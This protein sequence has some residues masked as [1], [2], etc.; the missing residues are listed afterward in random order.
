MHLH[1]DCRQKIAHLDIKPEIILLNE[2]FDAKISDFVLAKL[3]DRDQ[4]YIITRMRGTPG[5]L[6]PEWLT[7]LITEKADVYSFGVVVTEILCGR[8]N[9]DYTQPEENINL[10]SVI[11]DKMKSEQLMDILDSK[12]FSVESATSDIEDAIRMAKLA[13]WCLESDS[14]RRPAMSVVVKIIEGAMD[15]E[16]DMQNHI[17]NATRA[18]QANIEILTNLSLP[19]SASLLSGPR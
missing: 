5:Y 7:H 14:N 19:H 4:S 10:T 15:F 12:I 6:A 11:Q 1:E 13:M 17:F 9:L 8:R 16:N 18:T 2:N 3:I